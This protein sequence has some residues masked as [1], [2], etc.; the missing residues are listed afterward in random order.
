MPSNNAP[1][2]KVGVIG[3]GRVGSALSL[4]LSRAGHQ[5][6]AFSA[7]SE[8]SKAR[9]AQRF[10][11]AKLQSPETVAADCQLLVVAVPDDALTPLI[12]GLAQAGCF[13]EGQFVIHT[14]GRHGL[15]PLLPA[16]DRGAVALALHPAMTFTGE[17]ADVDRLESC[18]FAI[19]SAEAHRPVAEA[20]VLEMGG[21]PFWVDDAN[22][23]L[24]HAALSHGANHL[25]VLVEQASALLKSAGIDQPRAFLTPL[26]TAALENELHAG[27]SS[28]TGPVSRGDAG[29]VAA[30]LAELPPSI[31]PA[32]R[33]LA[34]G[35]VDLALQTG[36]IRA[37]QAEEIKR[38]VSE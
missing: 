16:I 19:T 28:L 37:A 2:L 18:P 13:H 24:Y 15:L 10:P 1:R 26:L 31:S 32:Y 35:A 20:L 3:V 8:A 33:V 21:E 6:A 12:S 14:S 25:V 27:A 36:R 9:G 22:R 7:I 11:L 17:V 23:V 38:L 4:A 34:A 5:V 30:H 29:T